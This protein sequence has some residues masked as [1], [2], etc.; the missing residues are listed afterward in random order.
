M[1]SEPHCEPISDSNK[2]I[3]SLT[4]PKF[5]HVEVNLENHCENLSSHLL[6]NTVLQNQL[7]YYD[8]DGTYQCWIVYYILLICI[9]VVLLKTMCMACCDDDDKCNT[10]FCCEC[11]IEKDTM[12]EGASKNSSNTNNS[13]DRDSCC[14]RFCDALCTQACNSALNACCNACGQCILEGLCQAACSC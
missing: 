12:Y 3:Y 10:Q 9:A 7:S 13:I 4:Q 2:I 14:F 1:D 11:Y 5:V 8:D 6:H